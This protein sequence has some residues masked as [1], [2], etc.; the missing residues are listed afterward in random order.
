MLTHLF[1][2]IFAARFD[3]FLSQFGMFAGSGLFLVAGLLVLSLPLATLERIPFVGA[4][5]ANARLTIAYIL[6]GIAVGM[7][8][9]AMGE[10]TGAALEREVCRAKIEAIAAA[11]RKAID[12]AREAERRRTADQVKAAN[13]AVDRLAAEKDGADREAADLRAELLRMQ[14]ADPK[15]SGQP[16]P[17]IILKAIRGARA[18]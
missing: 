8:C 18:K 7:G 17:P 12:D 4:F 3:A 2:A 5:I 9:Y 15:G 6:L 16:V 13:K 1:G 11:N 10:R 14:E